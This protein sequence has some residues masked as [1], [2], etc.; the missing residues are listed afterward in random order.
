MSDEPILAPA[1]AR[2]PAAPK[3]VPVLVVAAI[4]L[5]AGLIGFTVGSLPTEADAEPLA[6]PTA[7]SDPLRSTLGDDDAPVTIQIYSD[8]ACPFCAV[9]DQEVEPE[10]VARYVDTGM[11]RLVWYDVP[12]QGDRAAQ[13][14]IAG[15]AAERQDAFWPMKE[16]IFTS[17]STATGVDD[18]RMLAEQAGLDG[19]QFA[20]DLA[21]PVLLDRVMDDYERSRRLAVSGTPTFVIGEER[22]VG[23][24]PLEVFVA[25]IDRAL[26]P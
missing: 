8:F 4:A 2:E 25:A 12:L 10:L 26:A 11:A 17:G 21:D 13:L 22:I 24:Q 9:Y 23:A 1:P 20:A 16:A 6:A 18:L 15:R 19:E 3:G 7:V 14:A 5:V